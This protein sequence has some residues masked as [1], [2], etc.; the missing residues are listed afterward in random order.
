MKYWKSSSIQT[1]LCNAPHPYI[2]SSLKRV[3]SKLLSNIT[4]TTKTS[5]N[6]L[7]ETRRNFSSQDNPVHSY[8][9]KVWQI[10]ITFKYQHP[11]T[12][13]RLYYS[14]I[15]TDSKKQWQTVTLNH[16]MCAFKFKYM[17]LSICWNLKYSFGGHNTRRDHGSPTEPWSTPLWCR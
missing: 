7:G 12:Y 3:L 14:M 16:F 10:Y 6:S 17:I 2:S 8:T 9:R 5:G 11:L 13:R 1:D 15:T 4:V